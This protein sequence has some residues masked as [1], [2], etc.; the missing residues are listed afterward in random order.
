MIR[1]PN[2]R[3]RSPSDFLVI[4]IVIASIIGIFMFVNSLQGDRVEKISYEQLIT[5]IQSDKVL[6][7]N[8]G[9]MT[10]DNNGELFQIEG[11]YDKEVVTSGYL[12]FKIT[13]PRAY[14]DNFLEVLHEYQKTTTNPIQVNPVPI[15]DF[16]FWSFIIGILPILLSVAFIFIIF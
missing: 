5:D 8:H 3:K 14:Y 6:S 4:L 2:Q 1:K 15:S 12:A 13:L 16:N 9:P 7:I 10:G 11:R